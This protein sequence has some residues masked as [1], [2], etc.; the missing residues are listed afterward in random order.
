MRP[1][2]HHYETP[3]IVLSVA[4]AL[5]G[6]A[7]AAWFYSRNGVRAEQAKTHVEPLHRLLSGKYYIDELY[8]ALLGRP[9]RW[10]SDRIFLRVGDRLLLDG[11]LDGMAT[12]ARGAAGLLARVQTGSLHLYAF[13][14][15]VGLA[16]VL[17]WSWGHV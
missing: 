8:E 9:I 16:A 6:L 13:L 10:I 7:A 15:L 14:V 5:T 17:L 2:L 3:L 1:E 12:T 11:T 4:I